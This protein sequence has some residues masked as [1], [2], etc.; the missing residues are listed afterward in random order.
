MTI[1]LEGV[2]MCPSCK[3]T[4]WV[5]SPHSCYDFDALERLRDAERSVIA[6]AE[7]EADDPGAWAEELQSA[8]KALRLARGDA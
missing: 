2:T 1:H 6:M 4:V 3:K 8:V 7:C 5:S